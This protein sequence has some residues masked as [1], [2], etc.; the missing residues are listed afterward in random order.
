[1]A[2]ITCPI[3]SLQMLVPEFTPLIGVETPPQPYEPTSIAS[4]FSLFDFCSF[5]ASF[6]GFSV[7]TL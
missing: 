3:A 7:E 4:V 2:S 1:M 5:Q 6:A